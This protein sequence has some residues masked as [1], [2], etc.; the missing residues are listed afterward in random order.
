MKFGEKSCKRWA[1]VLGAVLVM[2]VTVNCG[3]VDDADDADD[4]DNEATEQVESEDGHFQASFTHEPAPPQ[5]G[6]AELHFE[7]FDAD[8]EAVADATITVEP[9]M[10]GHGHGSPETPSVTETSAGNYHVTNI[11]Y[12]MPGTW[13]LRIDVDTDEVSDRFVVTYEVE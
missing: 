6:D 1:W 9:W 13:D 11:V 5:T 4:A 2:F 7:L 8:E 3:D 12:S 10:P